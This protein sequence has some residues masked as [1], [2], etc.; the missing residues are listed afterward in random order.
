M[1]QAQADP[2]PVLTVDIL[3]EAPDWERVVP[4]L[5]ARTVRALN[6]AARGQAP[7]EVSVLYTDDER[8]AVLNRIYR[9]RNVPTNVLSF[10][11]GQQYAPGVSHMYGD[12]ALAYETLVREAAD[13]GIPLENHLTHLLVHGFLHL[14]GHDHQTD[15]EADRM[16]G[17]EIDILNSLDIPDPYADDKAGHEVGA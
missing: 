17:L 9:G 15:E 12:L 6:A 7:G 2:V 10:P 16:E 13:G 11:G 8:M 5:E 4:D 14:V 1:V 3:V